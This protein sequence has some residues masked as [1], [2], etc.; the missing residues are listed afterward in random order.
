VRAGTKL[1]VAYGSDL[2]VVMPL[3]DRPGRQHRARARGTGAGLFAIAVS[4]PTG[5]ELDLGFW[6]GDPE[7]GQ[8]GVVS[9]IN[10]K[11]Y[12]LV[13]AGD[14]KLGLSVP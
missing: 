6:I 9:A 10:K 14:I 12:A 3:L 5:Y 1:T 11:I 7:N 4:V 8:G 2:D 13:A